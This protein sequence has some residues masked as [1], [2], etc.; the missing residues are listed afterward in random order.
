MSAGWTL[1]RLL[2]FHVIRRAVGDHGGFAG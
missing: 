1:G 2:V